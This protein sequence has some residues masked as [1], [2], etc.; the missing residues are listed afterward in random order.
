MVTLVRPGIN[1]V[2][3]ATKGAGGVVSSTGT[4]FVAGQTAL[5]PANLSILIRNMDDFKANFGP[6]SNVSALL[7]DSLETAF[8]RGLGQAYVSRYVG[9][10]A[11]VDT[12]TL[13]D[14]Q[15]VPAPSIAIDSIGPSTT[16]YKVDIAVNGSTYVVI[17]KDA[18]NNV[19]H[20]SGNLTTPL[21][22]VT[23]FST[24]K[25]VR[26]RALG[27]IAPA[28]AVNQPLA[29]GTDD[30][31][32]ITDVQRVA[33][34]DAFLAGLGPG[35]VSIPGATTQAA[36]VGVANHCA[37]NGR[38]W[39][40][41]DAVDTNDDA[42]IEGAITAFRADTTLLTGGDTYV[43]V[44]GPWHI[45]PGLTA[46]TSRV[47]PSSSV[48]AGNIALND[49]ITKNPN[50]APAGPLGVANYT[51]KLTQDPWPD[52]TRQALNAAGFNVWTTVG[53]T[54]QLYGFRSLADPDN[55]DEAPWLQG[56]AGRMRM[57]IGQELY[58][59]GQHF[60]FGQLDGQSKTLAQIEDGARGILHRY[61]DIGALYGA[62]A[63][64]AYSVQIDSSNNTPESIQNGEFHARI[65]IKTSPFVEMGEFDVTKYAI[66]ETF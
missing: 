36:W 5:G 58:D 42:A 17:I 65:G 46:G 59:Y 18:T 21:D 14:T 25:F 37:T 32:N 9:P 19:L 39:G 49:A 48:V 53:D 27:T 7:Y 28:A 23:A 66:G 63:D 22:A 11:A 30:R 44:F 52:Q 13:N 56:T 10:A 8:R 15:A 45:I 41:L 47:V 34:L 3:G 29:G 51:T 1:V 38:R 20:E 62:T 50:L 31:A 2:I 60:M 16:G 43:S 6:R 4:W 54:I 24:S 55:P 26:V 12:V 40:L 57:A 61:Y 33:A 35:Q 64:K